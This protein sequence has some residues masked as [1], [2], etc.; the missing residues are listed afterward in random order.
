MALRRILT[1]EDKAL[2]KVCRPVTDFGDRTAQLLDDLRDTLQDTKGLGLAAPQVGILRRAVIIMDGEQLVEMINPEIIQRSEEE[3]GLYEGCLSCPG[4]RGYLKRPSTI[5]V[6]AQDR[7]GNWFDLV[8][9][10]MT[11]RAACHELDHLDGILFT[12]LVDE[13]IP[14]DLLDQWLTELEMDEPDEDQDEMSPEDSAESEG[15]L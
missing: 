14:E 4:L 8:C 13:V 11:A 7:E 12:D 6:H 9:E 3:E 10:G 2:H 5:T 1:N 15:T